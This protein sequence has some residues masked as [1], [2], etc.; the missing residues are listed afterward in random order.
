ML[1]STKGL[2]GTEAH[3]PLP[4][5]SWWGS[6]WDQGSTC[7]PKLGALSAHGN[8][9]GARVQCWSGDE[10]PTQGQCLSTW[11]T[12]PL[13]ASSADK[14]HNGTRH[15]NAA[16]TVSLLSYGACNS[17]SQYRE[18]PWSQFWA[19]PPPAIK[20]DRI[21][22]S[23]SCLLLYMHVMVKGVIV[24]IMHQSLSHLYLRDA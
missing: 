22:C 18:N 23:I 20:Y 9:S 1:P 2:S 6:Q 16:P 14:A 12:S 3:H 5:H 7:C 19:P 10:A 8:C 17:R 4:A 24:W 21:W 11:N 13:Q 15:E